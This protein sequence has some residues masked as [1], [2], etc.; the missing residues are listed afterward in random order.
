M[1]RLPALARRR[2]RPALSVCIATA[3]PPGRVAA[4]IA[5]LTPLLDRNCEVV[6]ALDDRVTADLIPAYATVVD[7][8]LRFPYRDPPERT[9]PWLAATC[10]GS[11]LLRLDADEVPGVGLAEEVQATIDDGR[12][13]HAWMPRRW[14]AP[15][16]SGWLTG[17]PW[18]PDH[19]LRLFRR[20]PAVVR[21]GGAMHGYAEAAGA[22]RYF[23]APLY[24]LDLVLNDRPS[25][26]A[27]AERYAAARPDVP[28]LA[29]RE[30]NQAYYVPEAAERTPVAPVSA[31]DAAAIDRLLQ[32]DVPAGRGRPEVTVATGADVESY[33]LAAPWGEDD[34]AGRVEMLDAEPEVWAGEV[35]VVDVRVY[36]E[37]SRVW[38]WGPEAQ[39]ALR[40]AQRWSTAG[41]PLIDGLR[42]AFPHELRPGESCRVPV[43]V[44]PPPAPGRWTLHVDLVHEHVRTFGTGAAVTALC[45]P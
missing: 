42:T 6:L 31:V 40:L 3:E 13:T 4:V 9:Q 32:P 19:Q 17:W 37:S 43:S 28:R 10:R 24:H 16:R 27:K 7:R 30:F 20:D 5:P 45:H 23:D 1:L 41:Q 44:A 18:Q 35:R 14:V 22:R 8:I 29:G 15:D 36:N 2:R 26:V 12:V 38:P 25:R 34:Y 39:P 21:V 11:W 33:W